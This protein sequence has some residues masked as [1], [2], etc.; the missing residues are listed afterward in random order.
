LGKD[1]VSGGEEIGGVVEIAVAAPG[2]SLSGH[3][4]L[5]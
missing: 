5:G 3:K 4:S 1:F 2:K